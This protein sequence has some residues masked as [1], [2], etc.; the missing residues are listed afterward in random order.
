MNFKNISALFLILLST[1]VYGQEEL[2]DNYLPINFS[3]ES[4]SLIGVCEYLEGFVFSMA[5]K[6]DS[7]TKIPDKDELFSI[8]KNQEVKGTLLYPN[9]KVTEIKYELVNHRG[10]KG[11][12]MKTTLGYFLWEMLEI[13]NDDLFVAINWWYCPP[14][15]E[16]DLAILN[17]TDSIILDSNNWHKNDDRKCDDDIKSSC[18][19]LFCALKYSSI[20][21]T[22]EYNHHNAAMQ[23][24][25]FVID[26]LQPNHGYD[27]TLM[28]FN[29]NPTTTHRDI[30]I[31]LDEA[32]KRIKK[33][34]ND[35]QYKK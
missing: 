16:I 7:L 14:A 28:D 6:S 8:V 24:V 31:V 13:N 25:R 3:I 9:D 15:N 29:N 2:P 12:Y 5:L 22:K 4:D 30:L 34:L 10:I 23:T 35:Y 17:M 27:H 19:S 33:E 11:I 32:K 20:E 18:W 21:K 26:D 1:F